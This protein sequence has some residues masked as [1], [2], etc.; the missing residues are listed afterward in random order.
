MLVNTE[1][2]RVAQI[3]SGVNR[4][5]RRGACFTRTRV[6]TVFVNDRQTALLQSESR[7]EQPLY[8][9]TLHP[10]CS[11]KPQRYLVAQRQFAKLLTLLLRHSVPCIDRRYTHQ[12]QVQDLLERI[13]A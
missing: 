6:H 9:V 1:G 4:A 2:G 13:N 3:A 7:V 5:V 12:R 11:N 10:C 8:R